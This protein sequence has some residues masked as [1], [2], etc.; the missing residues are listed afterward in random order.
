MLLKAD[1]LENNLFNASK[2]QGPLKHAVN[3]TSSLSKVHKYNLNIKMFSVDP[4][5]KK[6]NEN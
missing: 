6:S 4:L 1:Y 3:A 5:K 2:I